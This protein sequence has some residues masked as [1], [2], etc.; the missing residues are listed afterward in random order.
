VLKWFEPA[1]G[2]FH[3]HYRRDQEYEPDFVVETKTAKYLC[4]PKRINEM[5]ETDVLGK[6]EA[7]ALWCEHAS[8]NGDKPW[9]YLLIPNDAIMDNKTLQGLAAAYRHIPAK[10]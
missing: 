6:A 5:T 1:K 10:T 7:A 8:Q 4:E 2:Q 9:T 3:I